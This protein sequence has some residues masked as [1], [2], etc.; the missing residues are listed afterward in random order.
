MPVNALVLGGHPLVGPGEVQATQLAIAVDNLVLQLR[1][2]QATVD[3]R[4][5]R[6]ALHRRF[7]AGVSQSDQ[8]PNG[9][10]AA[11]PGLRDGG[12][13]QFG[14][15]AGTAAQSGV[16]TW[17]ALSAGVV[18]GPTSTAVHAGAVAGLPSTNDQRRTLAT[19]DDQAVG[20]AQP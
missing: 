7:R 11:P 8:I 16:E 1:C 19:M 13:P 2:R 12:A 6:F 9:D 10:D 20:R 14:P 5:P 15:I 17:P 18:S 4:Q 3:H